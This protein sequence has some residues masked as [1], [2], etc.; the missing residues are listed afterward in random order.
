MT[1]TSSHSDD[2]DASEHTSRSSQFHA[3]CPSDLRPGAALRFELVA[4]GGKKADTQVQYTLLGLPT[5][6][7]HRHLDYE[8][9]G[10]R[11]L[12]VGEYTL[13]ILS[14]LEKRSSQQLA[15]IDDKTKVHKCLP[16]DYSGQEVKIVIT[17]DKPVLDLGRIRLK[18]VAH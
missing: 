15:A 16:G 1:A 10:F 2:D 3:D 8:N 9:K 14:S 12:P 7:Y 11:G 13:K 6:D 17:K 5:K 4:P 18:A